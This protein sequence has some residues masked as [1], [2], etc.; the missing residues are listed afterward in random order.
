MSDAAN[1]FTIPQSAAF[2]DSLAQALFDGHLPQ[3]DGQK[4]TSLELTQY[5]LLLPTRRACRSMREAFL[6]VSGGQAALLPRIRPI[7]ETDE[8]MAILSAHDASL[9]EGH[10]DVLELPNSIGDIERRL[11]LTNL[12]LK[13]SEAL[14]PFDKDAEALRALETER[15]DSPHIS[16]TARHLQS[17]PAQASLLARELMRLMDEV[18]TEQV[19]FAKLTDIVP[20]QFSQHWELTLE[21]LKIITQM[22]P[23]FLQEHEML[24]PMAR[25]NILLQ[26]EAQYL[27]RCPPQTPVIAAGVTGSIPAAADVLKVIATLPQGVLVLPG[28]DM[29]LDQASWDAIC[30]GHPEHP[31]YSMKKLLDHLEV[32]RS[33]VCYVTGTEPNSGQQAR[34]HLI[35]E[36][37]RPA[38]TTHHWQEFIQTQKDN[39]SLK[40]AFSDVSYITAPTAEDEAE[41][42]SLILRRVAETPGKTAALVTSD[43]ILGRRVSTR[44]MKWGLRVDDS[45]GRPLTKTVPGVFMD[46]V[47]NTISSGFE[48]TALISLLQHPLARLGFEPG[49]IRAAA[50][51]LELLVLRQP[52]VSTDFPSLRKVLQLSR[53]AFDRGEGQYGIL[54]RLSAR[55]WDRAEDLIDKLEQAFQPWID[56]Y[57]TKKS[58]S[59]KNFA[60]VHIRVVE[61][62]VL[63]AQGSHDL[64]WSGEAGEA[65]SILI[66]SFLQDEIQSPEMLPKDYPEFYRSLLAGQAMRQLKAVHPRLYIWGP[67]EARLQQPDVV[68]MGGLNEGVWPQVAQGDPWLSRPMRQAIGLPPPEQRIGLFAHDFAHVLGGR[69]VYMTRAAKVD[70]VP[71][72]PSRWILR[73]QTLLKGL[74]L[75]QELEPHADEP[76]LAWAR[77]RDKVELRT[78]VKAPAPCPPIA[79]RPRKLSVTQVEDWIKNPYVIFARNIL[80]LEPLNP[81][82]LAP[83]AALR[84]QAIHQALHEFSNLHPR[85]LPDNTADILTTLAQTILTDFSDHPQV[86]AFWQPRFMRFAKWF[87]DTE[88][89]RREHVTQIITERKGLLNFDAPAGPFTLTARADRIDILENGSAVLYDYKSGLFPKDKEVHELRA[90]QLPLEA[91]IL[92]QGGFEGGNKHNVSRLH[93]ISAS[94]GEPPGQDHQIACNDID[95]LAQNAL[96][97]LQNL[98]S[99]F[100]DPK[101]PYRAMRRLQFEYR[102]DAYSHLARVAEWS[103]DTM[104]A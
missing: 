76:W 70:G 94:G 39:V 102:Y 27:R 98:V 14:Y 91:A 22:W 42:V 81:L 35:S 48:P 30:P 20:E 3:Q 63:D 71:T 46:L 84:G 17:K 32:S 31:Q 18:E 78:P 65:L 24:S 66:S 21:F 28:L 67:L 96:T 88:A 50:R 101:V 40:Q 90:P 99:R 79:S 87:A 77:S 51:S 57:R 26:S 4:P 75:E 34:L 45:A 12:I 83:D 103:S 43:R 62:L 64:L 61:A 82:G 44:L 89:N 16:L 2:L 72:V 47:V 33:Q 69:K 49:Q 97:K 19:D 37:M 92:L 29:T 85:T 74:G 11:V 54:R 52:L 60:D 100:D 38:G 5:T 25:R 6:R 23:A 53:G 80:K 15:S 58:Y 13:W 86:A 36:T 10:D 56:L 8:D 7:G 59:L 9:G 68:V 95:V 55:D 93:Y 1:I 41:V 104:S 73:L